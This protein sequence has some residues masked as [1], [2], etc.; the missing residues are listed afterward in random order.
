M[1]IEC[2]QLEKKFNTISAI[3]YEN[4]LLILGMIYENKIKNITN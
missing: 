4:T 2:N 1:N 3:Y